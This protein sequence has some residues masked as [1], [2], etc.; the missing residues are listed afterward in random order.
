MYEDS[1]SKGGGG[2]QSVMFQKPYSITNKYPMT[3]D[4]STPNSVWHIGSKC[5]T[6]HDQRWITVIS[7]LETPFNPDYPMN[8]TL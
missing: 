8:L 4:L 6:C 5:V 7:G 2:L 3:F 1:W